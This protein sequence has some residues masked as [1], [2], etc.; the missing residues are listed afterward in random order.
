MSITLSVLHWML[1]HNHPDLEYHA[2]WKLSR[3]KLF[4]S[5]KARHANDQSSKPLDGRVANSHKGNLLQ[6]LAS[7][8]EH[9]VPS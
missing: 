2:Q 9:V 1:L 5:V 7:L 3:D 6:P 8:P 4:S